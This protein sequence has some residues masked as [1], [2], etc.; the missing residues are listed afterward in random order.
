MVCTDEAKEVDMLKLT[1]RC[2]CTIP[3][4]RMRYEEE[5]LELDPAK[6][7][8]VGLHCWNIGCEDGPAIDPNFAVGMCSREA[9]GEA[10]RIMNER[11]APA[12]EVARRCGVAVCH[13]TNAHIA[14]QDPRAQ[15]D[16]DP[17]A[18]PSSDAPRP[19]V[20]GW[21]QSIRDRS[22]GRDYARNSPYAR[23]GRAK[24]VDPRPGEIYVFQTEQFDRALRREGIE[25]LI[26]TGFATDM[27]VLRAPGGIQPMLSLG[28]RTFLMRDA[29]LG[30]EYPDTFEQR[31]M[32][33]WGIRY[34]EAHLGDALTFD[35]FV[36]ACRDHMSSR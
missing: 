16:M 5:Q 32:T 17:P 25:N 22:H 3:I 19:V 24:V 11:I 28:Y 14:M 36:R 10:E 26:Y 31:T 20:P 9:F 6:T 2:F 34:F 1:G 18:L 21:T 23:M 35:G 7:A 4:D 30:V 27:C 13:V 12:M 33:L 29:T 15:H 8:L